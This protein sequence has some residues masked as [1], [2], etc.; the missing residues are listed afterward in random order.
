MTRKDINNKIEKLLSK[1]AGVD[2][3]FAIAWTNMATLVW[4]GK[5][6]QVYQKL[7]TY[8]DGAL[9][10]YEYDEV[11]EQSVCCLAI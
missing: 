1:V 10:N 7:Q 9:Y 3:T 2:I 4:D 8:F 5:N 6:E 11:C